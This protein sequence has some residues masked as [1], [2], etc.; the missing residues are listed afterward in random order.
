MCVTRYP[1]AFFQSLI[2]LPP[3]RNQLLAAVHSLVVLF[4]VFFLFTK[5]I[6]KSSLKK[7]SSLENLAAGV[8]AAINDAKTVRD[9]S[10]SLANYHKHQ[11]PGPLPLA[12]ATGV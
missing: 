6:L 11:E 7:N 12:C 5:S 1:S 8:K 3:L 4:G 10:V 2:N 9:L